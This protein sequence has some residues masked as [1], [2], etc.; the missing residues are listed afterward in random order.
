MQARL[1]Q[2]ESLI[3]QQRMTI[4][5]LHSQH[6]RNSKQCV[7][8]MR[9]TENECWRSW[10]Q[11]SAACSDIPQKPKPQNQ[12]KLPTLASVESLRPHASQPLIIVPTTQEC[13]HV[14]GLDVPSSSRRSG[15]SSIASSLNARRH[16]QKYS[17]RGT[18]PLSSSASLD[19]L[20]SVQHQNAAAL[21][22][23]QLCGW[24]PGEYSECGI[25]GC[26]MHVCPSDK[27]G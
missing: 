20:C 21:S 14:A 6:G 7:R 4:D 1:H 16:R 11:S 25:G 5:K 9:Q 26:N 24:Q 13:S 22:G 19:N 3:H 15:P 8:H 23:C 10:L 27:V 17:S 2:A 12:P 18:T